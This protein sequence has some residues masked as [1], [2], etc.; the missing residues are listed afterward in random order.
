[1]TPRL[2]LE[3]VD[4]TGQHSIRLR[5]FPGDRRIGELV[6]T[7]VSGMGLRQND[8]SGR[9]YTYQARHERTGSNLFSS[10]IVVDV[11]EEGDLVRLT[12]NIDAG[13]V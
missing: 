4:L 13:R 3:A 1:M 7:A 12:P 11:L 5:D 9:P 6:D 10:E 8:P 2:N